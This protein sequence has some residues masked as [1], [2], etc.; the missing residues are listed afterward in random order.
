M[1]HT[2][3]ELAEEFPEMKAQIHNLREADG[4]F[5]KLTDAYHD[6]NRAIHR[7]ETNVA[8]TDDLHAAD[9]RK[10]RL[11]LKDEIWAMLNAVAES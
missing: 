7:A 1:G 10:Q 4:H 2:P 5:A 8:P 3:H 11:A 6:I 9:M